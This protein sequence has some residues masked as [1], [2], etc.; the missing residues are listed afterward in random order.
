MKEV[1]EG[2]E[3]KGEEGGEGRGRG[4]QREQLTDKKDCHLW[5]SQRVLFTLSAQIYS[6]YVS[7]FPKRERSMQKNWRE[8]YVAVEKAGNNDAPTSQNGKP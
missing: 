4:R 1:G 7:K 2:R 8:T 5:R 3:R 6:A